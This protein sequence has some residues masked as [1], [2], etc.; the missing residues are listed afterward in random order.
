RAHFYKWL[1]WL[2]NT[3]QAS[4]MIYFYPD[5]WVAEGNV[6]GATEVKAHAE[7]KIAGLLDQP[8]GELAR[9]GGPWFAGAHYSALDPYVFVLCRWTRGFANE[10]PARSRAHLGPYL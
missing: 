4:L 6:G 2:T 7:S 3:L 1:M 9:H 5:R 10:A 8:D